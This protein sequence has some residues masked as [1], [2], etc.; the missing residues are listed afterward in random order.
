MYNTCL[1]DDEFSSKKGKNKAWGLISNSQM[2]I[3]NPF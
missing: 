2:N 1:V 3:L